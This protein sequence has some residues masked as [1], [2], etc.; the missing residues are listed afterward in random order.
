[1]SDERWKPNVTVAAVVERGGRYLLVEEASRLGPVLNN[2]AGHLD[3]G[4][5]LLQAVVRE[6]LEETGRAFTPTHLVGAYL[7]PS[8]SG[9]VTYLR[10]AFAGEVGEPEPGRALDAGILRTLWLTPEQIEAERARHRSPL[11]ARC[12]ADHRAGRRYPLELLR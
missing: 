3:R 6:V 2:P 12:I 4:E 1:M 8:A 10:F 7:A 11:L 9:E 5:T